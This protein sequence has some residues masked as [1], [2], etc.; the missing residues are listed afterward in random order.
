VLHLSSAAYFPIATAAPELRALFYFFIAVSVIN[1]VAGVV[2]LRRGGEA[3]RLLLGAALFGFAI[4]HYA[5]SR[6]D[7]SHVVNAVLV[8]LPLLPVS[9]AVIGST[10]AKL[11]G[12]AVSAAA[13]AIACVALQLV[14]PWSTENFLRNLRGQ[15]NK[16]TFVENGG[17]LFPMRDASVAR[18]TSNMLDELSRI[19]SPHQRV[20]VGPGDLRRTVGADTFLYHLLPS[21]EPATYYLEM[22]PGSTNAPGS[23]LSG[24]VASAD[25]LVLDRGWDLINEPNESSAYGSAEPNEVV[26]QKFDFWAEYGPYVLMRNKRLRNLLQPLPEQ[27]HQ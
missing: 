9:L 24:D 4:I 8:S 6:F 25:W 15:I 16:G 1:V 18:S 12:A 20:L 21:L 7:G 2:A 10:V 5:L 11:P 3:A 14:A 19:S 27:Q 22:N 23:R 26:R 17:R 13:T